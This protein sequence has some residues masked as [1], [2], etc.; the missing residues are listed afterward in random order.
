MQLHHGTTIG[1]RTLTIWAHTRTL[2]IRYTMKPVLIL[3][4]V[5]LAC[6]CVGQHRRV[7]IK[8]RMIRCGMRSQSV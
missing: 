6:F 3:F 2:T 4:L 5:F 7:G 8:T 1:R